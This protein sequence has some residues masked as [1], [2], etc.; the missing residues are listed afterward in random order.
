MECSQRLAPDPQSKSTFEVT[1]MGRNMAS[2]SCEAA[3]EPGK[4]RSAR[5]GLE[6]A[7]KERIKSGMQ[8]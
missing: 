6:T 3:P 5:S 2:G 4:G 7:V 8:L 1:A